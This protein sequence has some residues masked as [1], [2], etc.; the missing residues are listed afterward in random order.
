MFLSQNKQNSN[1]V[2]GDHP[3]ASNIHAGLYSKNGNV[4]GNVSAKKR[5]RKKT[6]RHH[7]S[8]ISETI[9]LHRMDTLGSALFGK[10]FDKY[11]MTHFVL[12]S[13]ETRCNFFNGIVDP[14]S[15]STN[16]SICLSSTKS[17]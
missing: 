14:K 9:I 4:N 17:R 12:G 7:L 1:S 5:K 2:A 6:I 13:E 15:F 16:L 3:L 8:K 10:N 11:F